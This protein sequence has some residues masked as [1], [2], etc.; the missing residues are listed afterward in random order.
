MKKTIHC[1]LYFNSVE[2]NIMYY[3]KIALFK[4]VT[5]NLFLK[6]SFMFSKHNKIANV[7]SK[8]LAVLSQ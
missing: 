8:P 1:L 7:Y 5:I 3:F 4:K 2:I 6:L